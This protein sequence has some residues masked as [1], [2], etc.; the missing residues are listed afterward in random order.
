MHKKT[1]NFDDLDHL[2]KCTNKVFGIVAVSETRITKKTP[3]AS[4]INLQNYSFN[5]F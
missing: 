2:L 1:K 4:D 5:S 3:L